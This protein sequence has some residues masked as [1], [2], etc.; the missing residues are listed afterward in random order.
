MPWWRIA[1]DHRVHRAVDVQQHAVLAAP[2]RESGVRAEAAGEEVVHDDRHAELLGELGAL[3]HLLR[4]RRGDVQ[5]VA[6]ALAGLGLGLA[7]RLGDEGEAVAP[8]HERLRVDVL[9]V[10]GEVEPAAQA[11]V[12]RAAVVLGRQAELGL[13]G[14]AEQ[15][16]AV[17]VHLVA[18][19]L[20]AVRRTAAGHHVGDREAHVLEPQR[21]DRLET[22]HV[23][24]ER[25]EDVDHRPFLEEVDRVGDEG[26]EAGVVAGHVLDAV[27]AALVV[28][29]IGQQVGPDRRPRAGRRLGGDGGGGLLARQRPP[30]A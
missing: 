22:E 12:H 10:L 16:P 14:A 20:D 21:A 8:A 3:V 6:L 1:V 15:R 19:D 24:D 11:L 26:V 18:L 28:L 25:G 30:A 2:V 9:V 13:D 29:E 5:V 23:A 27:G 7:D 4:G 17:L